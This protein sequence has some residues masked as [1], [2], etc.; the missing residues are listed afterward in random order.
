[1][2]SCCGIRSV[3]ALFGLVLVGLGLSRYLKNLQ[4]QIKDQY[5]HLHSAETSPE[6]V[7]GANKTSDGS[8]GHPDES[9]V[10]EGTQ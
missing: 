6:R 4:A 10:S 5:D 7:K 2:K 9:S 3:I 8:D 1:M